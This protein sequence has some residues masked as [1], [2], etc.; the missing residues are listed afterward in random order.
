M[1]V[2]DKIELVTKMTSVAMSMGSGMGRILQLVARA[3][4]RKVFVDRHAQRL[5]TLES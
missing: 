4:E 1:C 5:H 3:K 2:A